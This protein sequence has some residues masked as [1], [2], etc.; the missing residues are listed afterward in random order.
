MKAIIPIG[1]FGALDASKKKKKKKNRL[2]ISP[3]VIFAVGGVLLAIIGVLLQT[4]CSDI[5]E[6]IF[7]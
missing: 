3:T 1:Q 2:A 6:D 7:R 4:L 5:R